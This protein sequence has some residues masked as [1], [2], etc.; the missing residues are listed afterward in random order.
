MKIN[1]LLH[2]PIQTTKILF[3]VCLAFLSPWLMGSAD[4][5]RFEKISTTNGLSQQSVIDIFQDS[6]GFLW[7]GT[8]EGLNKYDGIG[9]TAYI[10]QFNDPT[11]ISSPWIKSIAEDANGNIWTGTRNGVSVLDHKTNKF[12][13]YLANGTR[14]SINDK[15][16]RAVLRDSNNTM[17]V[18]TKKGLNK[19]IPEENNFKQ[20]NF[21]LLDGSHTDI[22]TLIEDF[23]GNLWLGTDRNGL[24]KFN[25]KTEQVSVVI[26]DFNT[27]DEGITSGIRSL[28]IDHE[29]VLWIGTFKQGLY[30]FDLK[31]PKLENF[32]D[33]IQMV[34][35]FEDDSL[36]A[37]GQD[38]MQT[39]WI[40]TRNGLHY[41][42][43]GTEKFQ[44]LQ[45]NVQGKA[46][47]TDSRIWSVFLDNTDVFWVGTFDG[48][49]KWNTRTTQFD[50]YF[51]ADGKA[52]SLS[53]NITTMIGTHAGKMFVGNDAGLDIVDLST[54]EVSKLPLQTDTQAGLID[55]K[56]MS[57]LKVNDDEIWFGYR[58]SGATKYNPIEN[59]FTHY[60]Y[61][62]A[63]E[64]S[65]GAN[66]ITSIIK[67]TDGTI[68]FGTFN[69]GLNRYNRKTDNFTRYKFDADDISTL[70]SNKVMTLHES[71][72]GKLWVGTWDAGLN[73]FV[74]KTETA[75]R[76][77]RRLDDPDSLGAN[78]IL[79]I[80]EDSNRNI[81]VGTQG[82]G[83]N[84]LSAY[85]L[86]SGRITF[87]KLHTGNGMPSNVVY[88]VL[89]DE[90][91]FLWAS[92]NK[93][94]A[95]INRE[96]KEI[97]NYTVSQGIQDNEF[98]SGSYHKD[99]N[100]Y[101]YFGGNEGVT[102]FNPAEVK[103]NPTPPPI[104]LTH[105]Q[106]LNK[107]FSVSESINQKSQAIEIR[108]TDYLIG[109][110]FAALDFASPLNN[111]YKYKLEGFDTEWVEIRDVRR[112][113]YT[114]LP[115]GTYTFKVVASN[116]DGIWNNQGTSIELIVHPA[117]W[118]SWWAYT[119]Y[120]LVTVIFGWRIRCYFH[121]KEVMQKQ[122]QIELEHSVQERTAELREV[123][124]KLL[125]ISITDQ[126]TG[127]H[128]R[129][130]LS[131]VIIPRIDEISR[132]FGQNLIESSL[133]SESGPRLMAL[134]FDLD[135]FK[136]INDNYGHYAGDKVIIQVANILK[137]ECREH[138][139]VIR[140][141]GDEYMVVAEVDN[142]NE[143]QT[144]AER[145]RIAIAE[146]GF[147]VGL[148]N[149]F[150]LSSSLG[151]ALFPFSHHAPQSLSWDQVHLLA[152][153]ALYKSKEAGRNT[154][155]GIVQIEKELP[156]STLN[157]LVVNLDKA[158]KEKDV[159]VLRRRSQ[160]SKPK[161]DN[162]F[163]N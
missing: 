158:I 105:F 126:L 11:S 131:E 147:D 152:D 39:L 116:S 124:E 67:G 125:H 65:I 89:E 144:L 26:P 135:G 91:G 95:K 22:W 109:F 122:Y 119:I 55:D 35:G 159:K 81:W 46:G 96:T 13:R 112:A 151:F 146:H 92:T 111:N 79:T 38:A 121:Q 2:K 84:L 8:Q 62:N 127:L 9:F 75:F 10:T 86:D 101:L 137:R 47:L 98:N 45:K 49:N 162:S 69:G 108:H 70:S 36:N 63:D 15:E 41:K 136:P 145:I 68:W 94:L 128:N 141:G 6:R 71:F 102:R 129:R 132:R 23:A 64:N 29:Q 59:L 117:P 157:S 113:T 130:H 139:I 140:W 44:L 58:I 155:T 74:P 32:E 90:E 73:V 150:H 88:G 142:L 138:D 33:M 56:V 97:V 134:M 118:L 53:S 99:E 156:F 110:E 76:M 54:S 25:I 19:F 31:G 82:G 60:R 42:K 78:S 66:G 80:H 148:P 100:G 123:N 133:T 14:S 87:E 24:L 120:F 51:K 149:K 72:D 52:N 48:L 77:Q 57:M 17:W 18:A 43:V 20:F 34:A 3:F 160:K 107:V 12:T 161:K 104:E 21:P 93:A 37:I 114:N 16:V 7:F 83:L 154:W 163:E 28:Y 4:N 115:S 5:I 1:V 153:K 106:R 143:A 50:H 103:P 30:R 40:G 27:K 61:D 85:N